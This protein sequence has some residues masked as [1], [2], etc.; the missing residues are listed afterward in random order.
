M[1]LFDFLKSSK[2]NKEPVVKT[3]IKNRIEPSNSMPIVNSMPTVK[4]DK[5]IY[6]YYDEVFKIMIADISGI[7]KKEANEIHTIIKN[8]DGGF[9]NM[10]GYHSVIWDK[11]FK[12]RYWQWNE[13]EAWNDEFTILGRFP[14]RFPRKEETVPVAVRDVLNLLNVGELKTLCDEYKLSFQQK[15]RKKDLVELLESTP[16]ISNSS[17]VIA[18]IDKVKNRFESG[19]YSLFMRTI[20]FRCND[21]YRVRRTKGLG[22]KFGVLHT[23]EEDK[24]FVEMALKKQPNALHPLFPGDMSSRKSILPF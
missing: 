9:L 1:G 4:P 11:Y 24:E 20:K 16:N 2:N 14:S 6:D 8:C 23:F 5:E 10:S 7:T 17:L 22:L 21:L 12:G 15:I 18:E 13:Y 19:L 3:D